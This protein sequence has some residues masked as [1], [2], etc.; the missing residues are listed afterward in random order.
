M[1]SSS[2]TVLSIPAPAVPRGVRLFEVLYGA[3]TRLFGA[4]RRLTAAEKRAREAAQVR[5]MA[6]R[7][8]ADDPGFAADLYAAADRHQAGR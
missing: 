4:D 6:H 1:S 8:L 3:A 5:T 7:V 2:F